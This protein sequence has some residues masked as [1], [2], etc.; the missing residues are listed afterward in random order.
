MCCIV[1][2]SAGTVCI[3]LAHSLLF[4]TVCD[5]MYRSWIQLISKGQDELVLDAMNQSWRQLISLGHN[6][7]VSDAMNT[8][9]I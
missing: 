3:I 2:R 4:G 5:K 7:L 8:F 9:G 6:E 1:F